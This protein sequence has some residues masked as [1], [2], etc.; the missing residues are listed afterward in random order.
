MALSQH[1]AGLCAVSPLARVAAP[2]RRR[3]APQRCSASKQ[4][5]SKASSAPEPSS[6]QP[7]QPSNLPARRNDTRVLRSQLAAL[8][9]D[10]MAYEPQ[11]LPVDRCAAAACATKKRG[12]PPRR[13]PA[14]DARD[15]SRSPSAPLIPVVF[16]VQ[17]N[18]RLGQEIQ[19]VGSSPHLGEWSVANA[20]TLRWTDG[21]VWTA[22]VSLPAGA[23]A[24][25][26]APAPGRGA[27][28]GNAG[29]ASAARLSLSVA[30]NCRRPAR[31]ARPTP[32]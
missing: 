3:A 1:L 5:G 23:R 17:Y 13:V 8:S 29:R 10:L 14:P 6:P 4:S 28:P 21:G 31:A 26:P 15:A 18:T 9:Q 12:T 7:A 24:A 11:S 22:T 20:C 19:L 27:R 25:R 32:C 16:R 2:R 30:F